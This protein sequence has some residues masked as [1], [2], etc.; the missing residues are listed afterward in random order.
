MNLNTKISVAFLLGLGVF[1]SLSACIRLKYT[2]NLNNSSDFLY[3]IGDV[4]IWVSGKG[5]KGKK[6]GC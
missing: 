4:V 3:G 2:V 6:V 5:I 1:A